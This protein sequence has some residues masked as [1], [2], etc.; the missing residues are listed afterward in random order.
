MD[1]WRLNNNANWRLRDSPESNGEKNKG[2]YDE[3]S[4]FFK[5]KYLI[6]NFVKKNRDD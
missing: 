2:F 1:N 5:E 4:Q 6:E 3:F